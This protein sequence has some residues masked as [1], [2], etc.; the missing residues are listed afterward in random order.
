MRSPFIRYL[1]VVGALALAGCQDAPT[2][3]D[4]RDGDARLNTVVAP[5]DATQAPACCDPIIV[6]VPGPEE[7]CDPWLQLDFS[8][9]GG[10]NGD[11]MSST[12]LSAS[13]WQTISG[14]YD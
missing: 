10:G 13:D 2:F 9:D 5:D 8:C 12:G 6:V 4:Q 1:L 7:E 3:P 14:C 11:C